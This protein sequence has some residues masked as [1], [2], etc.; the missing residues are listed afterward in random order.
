MDV[1]RYFSWVTDRLAVGS[2]QAAAP[3]ACWYFFD[4]ILNL[5]EQEHIGFCPP[6]EEEQYL[7][8]P[9]VD[10]DQDAFAHS[11]PE[12]LAFLAYHEGRSVLVHCHAG[13]SRSVCTA[14]AYLCDK[15]PPRDTEAFSQQY[16]QLKQARP[17]AFPSQNFIEV[18]AAR[19]DLE[20]PP[21][22]WRLKR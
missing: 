4:A 14:L 8:L 18:V 10:G 9:F 22:G 16:A 13:M 7:W 15:N 12:A 17:M 3:P 11:L 5:S 21:L 2:I 19:Y 1:T 20:A 6:F